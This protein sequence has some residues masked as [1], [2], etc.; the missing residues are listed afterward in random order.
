VKWSTTEDHTC[1]SVGQPLEQAATQAV[2]PA[3]VA[4]DQHPPHVARV[5]SGHAS[6]GAFVT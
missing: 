1:E 3:K 5:C 4:A 2:T 6:H